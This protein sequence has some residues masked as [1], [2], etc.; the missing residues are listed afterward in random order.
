MN[1]IDQPTVRSLRHELFRMN[2]PEADSLRHSLFTIEEQ[3]APA[4]TDDLHSFIRVRN[5]WL[6]K[7]AQAA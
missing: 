6:D 7:Q 3:D 2:L 1:A 4:S 5:L